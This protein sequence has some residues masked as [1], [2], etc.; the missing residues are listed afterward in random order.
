MGGT[1]VHV[2]LEEAP[3]ISEYD[4]THPWHVLL[5]SA[6]TSTALEQMTVHLKEHLYQYPHINIADVAYTLHV[7]RQ[8]FNYRR[9][10]VCRDRED[11]IEVL[12]TNN[13]ERI[14]TTSA[15][16]VERPVVFMFSGQGAQYVHM[17][18]GLYQSESVFREHLDHC[19]SLLTPHLGLDIRDLLFPQ[20][21]ATDIATEQLN[22]TWLTQPA[23]F[24]VEYALAQLWMAWGIQPRAMIGHSI[25]EYVAA[26]LAGVFVLEDALNLV[27]ARGRMMQE[28]PS[29]AMLAVPLPEEDLRPLLNNGLS[30]AA[31]NSP[32]LCVVSGP[33][34][35]VDQLD[36]QLS[37]KGLDCRR[38]HTSHAF[39][40]AMMES[41]LAPFTELVESVT[42]HPTQIPYI[43]NLTG[44]WITDTEATNPQYW[45]KHLR[46]AVRFADGL[47]VLFQES[48]LLLLEVGPGQTLA[49]LARQHP[50]RTADLVVVSSLRH[51]RETQ[52]DRAV[53]LGAMGRLWLAGV[54]CDATHLYEVEQRTRIPLPTYPFERQ[55]YWL[56]PQPHAASAPAQPA[57]LDGKQP[58]NDWLYT[59]VWKPSPLPQLTTQ[60]A[61]QHACWVV[62]VD[63]CGV[64]AEIANVLEQHQQLVVRVTTT[65]EDQF[66]QI[67]AAGYAIDPQQRAHYHIMV[68]ELRARDWLPAYI[69]HAW[70][71][72]HTDDRSTPET[73][74]QS[75]QQRGYQ[76]LL[77]LAQ[78][79]GTQESTNPTHITMVSTQ[80]HSVAGEVAVR[81]EKATLLGPCKGIPQEYPHITCQSIDIILPVSDHQRT[82]LAGQIVADS[83]GNTK[84][85]VVAY[86]TH[87]RWEQH[88]TP[89]TPD[90]DAAKPQ[91]RDQ[92]I[93][94]IT[95][96]F[97]ELGSIIARY[98]AQ[99]VAAQLV[100]VG[101]TELPP[102]TDWAT[103]RTSH[104]NDDSVSRRI[105]LV[106][107]LE[108]LGAEVLVARADVA[109]TD[110]LQRAIAQTYERFG[111]LHG[112][113]HAAGLVGRAFF[114]A[115]QDAHTADSELHFPAKI[116]GVLALEQALVGR[117]LDFCILCS[118]MASILGGIG[119]TMYAAANLFM[120]AFALKQSQYNATPWI[121]M[122]WDALQATTE[123]YDQE[124]ELT[125]STD[126]AMLVL[127]RVL[128]MEHVPQIAIS[129]GHLTTRMT[130][131]IA[132]EDPHKPAPDHPAEQSGL[133][134]RPD[135]PNPYVAPRNEIEHKIADLW[136]E[137]LG[138]DKVGVY[139]NFFDLGGNSLTGIRVIGHVKDM[140]GIQIPAV[141]LYEGPSVSALTKLITQNQEQV[142][143]YEQSLSRGGRRREKRRGKQRQI[144]GSEE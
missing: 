21:D 84:G 47:H 77:Y 124:T 132:L 60:L 68:A 83:L 138:I 92:G 51:P 6:K 73:S 108:S 114:C 53:L 102:R 2:I 126:E 106:Q 101:R 10:F 125:I 7:G 96:G 136:R 26:C 109:R 11:A 137:T 40:S 131:W 39:H 30:L 33:T 116:H 19:A 22:Q 16:S 76:S 28:L 117:Q 80:L 86:R 75:A 62:F 89:T 85:T 25:G 94:L 44:T 66:R 140:F 54:P 64:G 113:I 17:A 45:A 107:E 55:R 110:E 65:T 36:R 15:E 79:L 99:T 93:Y 90:T 115:I 82:R 97:G 127:Q 118:S 122:N 50:D 135:L 41:V 120:D 74:L 46:H 9:M 1:N 56:D 27:A 103:W 144:G 71:V 58:L 133:H 130:R 18:E 24:V 112:V 8:Q 29:G 139:D 98:L 91:L 31:V 87:Q 70:S 63:D 81:P 134:Q 3:S 59:P 32:M 128:S 14:L 69:I 141:S 67:G 123:Q 4:A 72:T 13:P 43:S 37:T 20:N 88:F 100:L 104:T 42:L 48:H 57:T 119:F 38:L 143:T 5:L 142:P 78:A 52:P 111:A 23:L 35:A 129:T 105:A 95:G 121:S 34:A 61:N 49:T 12:E